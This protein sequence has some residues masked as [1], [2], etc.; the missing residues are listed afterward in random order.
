VSAGHAQMMT[1]A[2][3]LVLDNGFRLKDTMVLSRAWLSRT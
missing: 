3:L 2:G 1:L